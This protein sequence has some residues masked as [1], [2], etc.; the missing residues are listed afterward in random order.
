[1]YNI[2]KTI[3]YDGDYMS[4]CAFEVY[5]CSR[6]LHPFRLHVRHQY[7]RVCFRE[8]C[9]GPVVGTAHF[10]PRGHCSVPGCD[11]SHKLHTQPNKK[12]RSVPHGKSVGGVSCIAGGI[13]ASGKAQFYKDAFINALGLYRNRHVPRVSNQ[14]FRWALGLFGKWLLGGRSVSANITPNSLKD[15]EAGVHILYYKRWK[16]QKRLT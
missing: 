10:H 2:T 4:R 6:H 5:F 15:E 11:R 12:K 16:I 3:K 7:S 14:K 8:F 1:M 9:G 13:W